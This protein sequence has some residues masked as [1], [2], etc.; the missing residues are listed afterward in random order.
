MQ[1]RPQVSTKW[2]SHTGRGLSFYSMA[3]QYTVQ[4]NFPYV[5]HVRWTLESRC[6]RPICPYHIFTRQ[7]RTETRFITLATCCVRNWTVRRTDRRAS[8]LGRITRAQRRAHPLDSVVRSLTKAAAGRYDVPVCCVAG[9]GRF[10]R[11]FSQTSR[12]HRFCMGS[13]LERTHVFR[14]VIRRF[15]TLSDSSATDG[16][17]VWL[18][19]AQRVIG[20]INIVVR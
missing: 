18:D 15:F 17:N 8:N 10:D 14:S 4:K 1:A 7:N 9:C 2:P 12:S 11:A 3:Q 13:Y 16:P 19:V 5:C 20:W 6:T